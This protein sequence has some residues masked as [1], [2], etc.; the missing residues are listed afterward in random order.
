MFSSPHILV[1]LSVPIVSIAPSIYTSSILYK[2]KK[3]VPMLRD[4]YNPRCHPIWTKSPSQLILLFLRCLHHQLIT[5]S[6]RPCLALIMAL[7]LLFLCNY[8]QLNYHIIFTLSTQKY[9]HF[10][11]KSSKKTEFDDTNPVPLSR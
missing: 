10:F 11:Q 5:G 2:N 6:H 8:L 9:N 3:P 1:L 4:E 7:R